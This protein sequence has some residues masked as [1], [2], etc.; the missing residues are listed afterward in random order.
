LSVIPF[1]LNNYSHGLVAAILGTEWGIGVR[2]GCFC[3]HPYITRLL[4]MNH[5]AVADFGHSVIHGD[6]SAM[7]GLVRLSFG[8]Y[9]TNQEIDYLAEALAQI[10]RGNFKGRYQ[11]NKRTGDYFV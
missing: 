3:A 10:S 9:N 7:P 11:Q 8:V 5:Q 2:S 4:G 1:K 6:K